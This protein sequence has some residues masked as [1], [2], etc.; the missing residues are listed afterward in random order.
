M[1]QKRVPAFRDLST[2]IRRHDADRTQRLTQSSAVTPPRRPKHARRPADTIDLARAIPQ[3][4]TVGKHR[5]H[6]PDHLP[7]LQRPHQAADDDI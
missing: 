4:R 5:R 6:Q 2:L 1:N 7:A 3:Q